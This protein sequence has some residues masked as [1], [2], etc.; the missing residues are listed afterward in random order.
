[1]LEKLDLSKKV[2]KEDYNKQMDVLGERLG[3]AQRMARDAKRPI[4]IVFEGWRGARRSALI[5]EMMQ[6]MDA[7]GF[8]VYSSVRLRGV[9]QEQPFFSAFWKRLP[10][11]GHIA[12]YHRS[13]YYLKNA[14]EM[15]D[16]A[17]DDSK[18]P[19]VSFE[20]INNFEKML[21]DDNYLVLKFFLHLSPEQ[22]KK[23]IAKNAKTLGKAWR[24]LNPAIDESEDYDKFLPHYEKML[25]ATDTVN[26]PWH[27]IA[28]DDP[29]SARLEVFTKIADAIEKA[30]Q[31]PVEPA[32]DKRTAATY[33][34][35][36]TIDAN[37]E[38]T[39]EEY[40]EKLDKYQKKLTQLQIE[41]FKAQIPVVIGF[42]GWDAAG[43]GGAIR[44][45]TAALDPLGFHVHPIAAP[46]VVEKQFHY[47]WRFWTRLPQP[48]TIAIFDRTWYGRVM[49]ER[50][51][52]FC[53]ENDW[54][55]AYNEINEFEK[56]LSDWGAVIIK[57]WVQIDKDTQLARFTER[58]NNPEK[59]WKITEED[60][61][62]REKWDLYED[63][64]DE[65]LKKTSTSF[66]P[67]HILESVDKKY[68]RIKALKIVIRE[69]EKH[70]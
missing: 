54:K 35:L 11:L 59:Q 58:Q 26:A 8:N 22:Q 30:V 69:L 19:V 67:W 5:N 33:D 48:G 61:R 65:M 18:Y 2:S 50:L 38:L 68:A 16:K 63:A 1:M 45:L 47:Q 60:W 57:F 12:V 53:T 52:G 41:M 3:K 40:K 32:A 14:N 56:E 55:R 31:M 70:I 49:V 64:V 66:A 42:E 15:A 6:Q 46:N 23:N 10:A 27:L 29:R 7:R 28:D 21:T 36:S 62:N 17:E 25:E 9:L 39:K 24:D 43:K 34:V 37:K 51:E 13:W 20:H 44:R 4:I